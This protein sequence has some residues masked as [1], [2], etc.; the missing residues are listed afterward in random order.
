MIQCAADPVFNGMGAADGV[1]LSYCHAHARRKFEQVAKAT[2]KDGLAKHAL[3]VF[4]R[5]Y[6]IEREAADQ[7]LSPDERKQSRMEKSDP[8]LQEFKLWLDDKSEKVLPK[9]P[10][11]KA[12]AYTRKHWE[13]LLVFLSDGRV[14]IDNN[15]TE[16]DIKPFVIARKNFMFACSQEGADSLGILFTLVL[17]ARHHGMDP[18]RYLKAVFERA[19][20]CKNFEDYEKLLPWAISLD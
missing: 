8:V 9:S 6:Q 12:M 15:A 3:R 11:G 18:F 16:R 4:K 5:L 19:P 13:G 10:L 17:T 2:K 14:A 7:G 1:R 20:F